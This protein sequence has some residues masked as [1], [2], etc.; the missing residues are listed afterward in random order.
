M[1]I[2]IAKGMCF[3]SL[4]LW[5]FNKFI[6]N[7]CSKLSLMSILPDYYVCI[8][9]P[10]RSLISNVIC[11]CFWLINVMYIYA[12][13]SGLTSSKRVLAICTAM[14]LLFYYFNLINDKRDLRP[15]WQLV[16][17]FIILKSLFTCSWI[18][19]K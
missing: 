3:S 16:F 14:T 19:Y 8:L 10:L 12:R 1:N 18:P 4:F 9:W 6:L 5:S 13:D 15:I 2:W 11:C 17:S 7:L